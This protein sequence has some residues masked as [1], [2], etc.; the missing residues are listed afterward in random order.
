M[1]GA[2]LEVVGVLSQGDLTMVQLKEIDT[3]LAFNEFP[4]KMAQSSASHFPSKG[5]LSHFSEFF[6]LVFVI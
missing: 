5:T 4:P 3:P 2:M 6:F 1:P